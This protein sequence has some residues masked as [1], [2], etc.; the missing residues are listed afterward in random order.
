MTTCDRCQKTLDWY[1]DRFEREYRDARAEFLRLSELF[2][3]VCWYNFETTCREW[4]YPWRR[5]DMDSLII[6]RAIVFKRKWNKGNLI[7]HGH[8]PE[9]YAGCVQDAPTLP[10]QIVLHELL[11]A[12]DYMHACEKQMTAPYDWSPGG[13]L[14]EHLRRTTAVGQCVYPGK[15]RKCSSC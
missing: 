5:S 4:R 7:E 6:L 15:R 12:R 13:Q 11:A 9:W 8:F 2:K 1:S 3:D 10:P 14:Y